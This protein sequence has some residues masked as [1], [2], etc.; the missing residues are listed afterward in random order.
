MPISLVGLKELDDFEA[1][2]IRGIVDKEQKRFMES[3]H[4][5]EPSLIINFKTKNSEPGK[6]NKLYQIFM[7]LTAAGTKQGVFDI[8]EEEWELEKALHKAF[9]SMERLIEHKLKVKSIGDR[10]NEKAAARRRK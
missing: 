7:K 4:I 1:Q 10:H 3:P 2:K 6:S 9:D 5:K 8:R